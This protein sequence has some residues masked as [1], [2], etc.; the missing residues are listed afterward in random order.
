M[1]CELINPLNIQSRLQN[2]EYS[3]YAD[4]APEKSNKDGEKGNFKQKISFGLCL[5][6]KYKYR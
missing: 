1:T 3:Q 2:D 6:V 4:L 5:E